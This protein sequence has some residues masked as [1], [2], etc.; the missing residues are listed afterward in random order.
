MSQF[1]QRLPVSTVSP[2]TRNLWRRL[3]GQLFPP[4]VRVVGRTSSI[5]ATPEARALLAAQMY[6]D[7][8]RLNP[9]PRPRGFVYK[10][11]TW[12]K[13]QQWRQQQPNPWLW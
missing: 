5:P 2:P 1:A 3:L 10:A 9:Y 11:K 4:K 7:A 13:Y 12:E 8:L 6:Q